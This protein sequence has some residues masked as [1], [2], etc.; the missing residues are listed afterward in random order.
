MSV[1]GMQAVPST[2]ELWDFGVAFDM[3]ADAILAPP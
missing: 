2:I 3:A 1:G